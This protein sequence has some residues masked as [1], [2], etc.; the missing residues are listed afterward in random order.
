MHSIRYRAHMK[1]CADRLEQV[2]DPRMREIAQRELND[3]RELVARDSHERARLVEA[4][5]RSLL[6]LVISRPLMQRAS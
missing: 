3:W 4:N 5:L 1:H 6:P 2:R